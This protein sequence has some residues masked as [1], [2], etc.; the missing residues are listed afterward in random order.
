MKK[1]CSLLP[2]DPTRRVGSRT[3][4]IGAH[5]PTVE[6]PLAW[7]ED[8]PIQWREP[9]LDLA[10]LAKL[11]W[12]EGL[13]RKDHANRFG[14]TESAIQNYFQLLRRFDFWI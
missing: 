2:F 10:E 6:E 13:S 9:R 5:R 7:I 12:I 11:R 4:G 3:V 14:R 8:Y 1:E